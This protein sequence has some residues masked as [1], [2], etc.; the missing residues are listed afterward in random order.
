MAVVL[1]SKNYELLAIDEELWCMIL[2][3]VRT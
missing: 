2:P 1:V 3:H